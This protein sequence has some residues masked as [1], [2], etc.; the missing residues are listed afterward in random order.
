MD[1]VTLKAESPETYKA[2][3]D[4]GVK[5]ERTRREQL[6]SFIGINAEGDKAVNEAVA[7]GKEYAEVAPIL[8]AATA[9]GAA[10]PD[11]GENAPEVNGAK[12]ASISG[13]SG[14]SE[15]EEAVFKG[16]GLS[17]DDV[18]KYGGK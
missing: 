10:K 1:L 4:E 2:A 15:N 18:K 5:A 3:F 14:H 16:L 9:R 8:A 6:M 11:T 7:N 12:P 17:D 13:A